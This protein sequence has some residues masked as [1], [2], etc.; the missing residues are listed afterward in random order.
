[1]MSVSDTKLYTVPSL[2][3]PVT[4]STNLTTL[5]SHRLFVIG[6]SSSRFSCIFILFHILRTFSFRKEVEYPKFNSDTCCS[7]H[8]LFLD[9]IICLNEWLRD[10]SGRLLICVIELV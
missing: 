3:R 1:M 9:I 4:P 2:I 7:P 8:R 6:S 5:H 10:W